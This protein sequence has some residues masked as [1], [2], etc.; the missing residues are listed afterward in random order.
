MDGESKFRLSSNNLL[1]FLLAESYIRKPEDNLNYISSTNRFLEELG[2]D[3]D[4]FN[5]TVEA[6][7]YGREIAA[8]LEKLYPTETVS[9]LFSRITSNNIQDDY[10]KKIIGVYKDPRINDN[11]NRAFFRS[12]YDFLKEEKRESNSTT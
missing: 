12:I 3:I 1:S 6:D 7:A 11:A 10:I 8:R 5:Q 2:K 9:N 4:Y